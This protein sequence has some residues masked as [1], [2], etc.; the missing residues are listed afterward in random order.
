MKKAYAVLILVALVT[1]GCASY[2]D[3]LSYHASETGPKAN[4]N[5]V[6][7]NDEGIITVF[8]RGCKGLSK[9]FAPPVKMGEEIS[10]A[11]D[12]EQPFVFSISGQAG[13]DGNYYRGCGLS[14]HFIPHA[15]KTYQLVYFGNKE[16][17][18]VELTELTQTG[19]RI[20]IVLQVI[21][22]DGTTIPGCK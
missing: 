9:A 10:K 1:P 11:I 7:R 21:P 22:K 12:A 16:K 13:V 8:M 4:L 6:N 3:A 19:Q 15:G 2:Y 20:P 17:C 5:L 18:K 14:A